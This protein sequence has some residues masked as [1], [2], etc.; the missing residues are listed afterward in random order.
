MRMT[1]GSGIHSLLLG[2]IA[3]DWPW[4]AGP[5]KKK[6]CLCVVLFSL[7]SM[8]NFSAFGF[9]FVFFELNISKTCTR[10]YRQIFE[11][12]EIK[13]FCCY[14]IHFMSIKSVKSHKIFTK[15]SYEMTAIIV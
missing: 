9:I 7:F 8:L 15:L 6:W 14:C 10:F 1:L 5:F 3:L 4:L 11:Y 13:S 2:K 12:I